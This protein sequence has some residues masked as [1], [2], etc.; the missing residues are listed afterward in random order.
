[1]DGLK[2][3]PSSRRNPRRNGRFRGDS[4]PHVCEQGAH[5]FGRWRRHFLEQG[6]KKASESHPE[7]DEFRPVA[8]VSVSA[9][10]EDGL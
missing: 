8:R 4:P 3:F 5:Q 6:R 10:T 9:Y 1:M 2:T 7:T